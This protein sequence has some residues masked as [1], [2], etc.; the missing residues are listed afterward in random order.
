METETEKIVDPQMGLDNKRIDLKHEEYK[1]KARYFCIKNWRTIEK[2]VNELK[3][4]EWKA[5]VV[6][7]GESMQVL[8]L[9][10]ADKPKELAESATAF[11]IKV[12]SLLEGKDPK[13]ET[14]LRI[15]YNGKENGRH[16]F[17]VEQA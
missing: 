8:N 11:R 13:V 10:M 6:K 15:K 1:G 16:L 2:P 7:F 14:F 12:N 5:D 4:I 3:I 17:D 9:V